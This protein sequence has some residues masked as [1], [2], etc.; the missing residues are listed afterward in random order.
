M[1]KLNF[2]ITK[3]YFFY[4]IVTKKEIGLKRETKKKKRIFNSQINR[5]LIIINLMNE[6]FSK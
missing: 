1:N 5:M 3:I 6:D 4:E 2:I